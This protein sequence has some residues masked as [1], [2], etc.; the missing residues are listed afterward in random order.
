MNNERDNLVKALH[1]AASGSQRSKIA[2]LRE[3]FEEVEAAKAAGTSNKIIVSALEAHGLIFD[4]N[5]FKNT[6]SRILK[7]RA[8]ETFA[9]AAQ[10]VNPPTPAITK[11]HV[12]PF[13]KEIA[14]PSA[15]T[16]TPTSAPAPPGV[17]T[18][19]LRGEVDLKKYRKD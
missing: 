2:R 11:K 8:M 18:S 1:E 19:I 9:Q 16:P 6:R 10:S 3:I 5:N 15:P 4:V 17:L 13:S 7:E 12:T 14:F